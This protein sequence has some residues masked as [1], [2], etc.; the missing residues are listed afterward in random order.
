M[1]AGSP[2]PKCRVHHVSHWRHGVFT[3]LLL[4]LP[5]RLPAQT[6]LKLS[7]HDTVQ[8]ISAA[9]L[10]RGLNQAAADHDALVLLSLDTPGGL[11]ESTRTMVSAIERSP[12]PVCVFVSPTGARAGSAGLFLLESADI[13]AMAPGTNAGA[14]HPIVEGRTLDPILKQKIEN[15]AAAFLRSITVPR[16]RNAEAAEQAVRNSISNSDTEALKLHLIDLI[17]PNDAS[18]LKTL[19]GRTIHRFDGHAQTLNLTGYTVQTFAPSV[20]E[21]FL[22]HLTDPDLAILLL[23]AGILLIY[24]E[25]N[26]PGTIIPG[27]LGTLC[28]LL[29]LFGLNLLPLRGA[30]VA[31]L[32]IGLALLLAEFKF[33]SHGIVAS[34]GILAIVFGLATLVDA[35]IRELRVHPSTAIATGLAFGLI[36]FYLGTIAIRARRNKTLLGPNAMI[37]L[38]A[39]VRSPLT[40][41]GQVEVRGELWQATLPSGSAPLAPG[42]SVLVREAHGF[43][44]LVEPAE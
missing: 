22:T 21:R 27:A 37:G 4:C 39:I 17:E 24:L 41:I 25:F 10:Q 44:L 40:P 8:P 20:R 2:Y 26:V 35:P 1:K 38:L 43:Q 23:L 29:A 19:D 6:V 42:A 15:D 18:L 36:T 11:L 32:I 3:L 14:S 9:Y 7:L 12:V 33:P 13:A 34:S 28:V 5:A 16:G 31:L 30:S